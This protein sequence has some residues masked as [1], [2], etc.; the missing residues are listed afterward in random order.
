M[1]IFNSC[2][3]TPAG[4]APRNSAAADAC[5]GAASVPHPAVPPPGIL[6]RLPGPRR[7]Q[8]RPAGGGRA[9]GHGAVPHA[10]AHGL[11]AGVECADASRRRHHPRVRRGHLYRGAAGQPGWVG[12]CCRPCPGLCTTASSWTYDPAAQNAGLLLA[13]SLLQTPEVGRPA[14]HK[15]TWQLAGQAHAC[16]LLTGSSPPRPSR[17]PAPVQARPRSLC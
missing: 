16:R 11:A 15:C 2:Q 10:G 1:I 8:C 7:L 14:A 4:S 5:K 17:L 3:S 13:R 12:M 6:S 9:A